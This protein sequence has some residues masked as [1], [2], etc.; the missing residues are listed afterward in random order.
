MSFSSV[1][2]GPAGQ[3]TGLPVEAMF[4]QI[5]SAVQKSVRIVSHST[6]C[7]SSLTLLCKHL[8][9]A[10][11]RAECHELRQANASLER[12]LREGLQV[13][14]RFHID[15]DSAES[16]SVS[17]YRLLRSCAITSAWSCITGFLDLTWTPHVLVLI[18]NFVV[19][20]W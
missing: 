2:S 15:F 1:S 16:M 19:H 6:R 14:R 5:M 11:L 8:E 10:E 18:V 13:R 20:Q 17:L 4:Q 7:T 12:Q 9:I 3:T